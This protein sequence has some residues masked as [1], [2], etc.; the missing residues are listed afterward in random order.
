MILKVVVKTDDIADISAIA[1]ISFAD[2]SL[3]AIGLSSMMILKAVVKQ[4]TI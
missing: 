2:D 3:S 4:M 1:D